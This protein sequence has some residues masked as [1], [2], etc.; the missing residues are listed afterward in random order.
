MLTM[1]CLITDLV[2]Y[3]IFGVDYAVPNDDAVPDKLISGTVSSQPF[4]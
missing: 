2:Q 1:P 3:V 4:K